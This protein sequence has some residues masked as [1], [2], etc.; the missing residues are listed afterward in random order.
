[1]LNKSILIILIF[2]VSFGYFSNVTYASNSA[3]VYLKSSNKEVKQGEEIEISVNLE[4]SKIVAC[5]FSLYFEEENFEYI[6][7]LNNEDDIQNVNMV[8]NK[9]NF[10]WFDKLGG[11]GAKEGKIASFKFRAKEGGKVTFTI[12][13]EFYN[14]NGQLIATDFESKEVEIIKEESNLQNRMQ[15]EKGTNLESSNCSLQSLRVDIQGLV[16]NFDKDIEEYYLVVPN[17]TQSIDI[18]AIGE[19]PN[20]SVEINGNTELKEK[21]SDIHIK[22]TSADK[23]QSKVYIIHVSKEDDL[24]MANTNLEILAIEDALLN[25]PFD[26]SETNYKVEV[27]NQTESLNIFAVPEN[28]QATVQIIGK[29]N[30][31]EGNNLVTVIVKAQNGFTKKSYIINVNKRNLVEEKKYQE[32]QSK[33]IEKLDNAYKIEKISADINTSQKEVKKKENENNKNIVIWIF[34][35]VIV[36]SV[37][38][39][40]VWKMKKQDKKEK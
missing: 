36:L 17:Y 19:N 22:V 21:T 7:E 31:K 32:E 16:P 2:I 37:I 34:S 11:D 30:L 3:K 18:F 20:A 12:D 35:A 15:E 5:N 13:G 33:Q 4:N 24:E 1:M 10:V 40:M 26:A 14:K 23:T 8:G 6:S 29:D 28:E 39:G 9:L 38:F 25:P 27:P